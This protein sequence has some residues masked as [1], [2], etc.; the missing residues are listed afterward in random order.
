MSAP[1]SVSCISLFDI[2]LQLFFFLY[3]TI[4]FSYNLH[5]EYF[6]SSEVI[7]LAFVP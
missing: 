3:G 1:C 6:I 2:I 7:V 4:N 5:V